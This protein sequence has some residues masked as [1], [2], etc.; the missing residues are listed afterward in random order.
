MNKT[1]QLCGCYVSYEKA[2]IHGPAQITLKQLGMEGMIWLTPEEARK[3]AE[4]LHEA[5]AAAEEKS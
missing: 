4:V 5:A 2:S 1:I 3:M